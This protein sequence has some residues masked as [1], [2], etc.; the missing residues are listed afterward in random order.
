MSQNPKPV[1]E[2]VSKMGVITALGAAIGTAVGSAI[3]DVALGVAVGAALGVAAGAAMEFLRRRP[4]P[5]RS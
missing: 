3:G 4:P 5:R 2:I 1:R